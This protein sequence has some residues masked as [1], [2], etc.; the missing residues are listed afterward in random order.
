MFWP[1]RLRVR[2]TTIPGEPT[3]KS[4]GERQ[5]LLNTTCCFSLQTLWKNSGWPET[6]LPFAGCTFSGTYDQYGHSRNPER[7]HSR[8]DSL[9]FQANMFSPPTPCSLRASFSQWTMPAG[10]GNPFA[11]AGW[12]EG[13]Q[14]VTLLLNFHANTDH[15]ESLE[16]R[17]A[18][19][20]GHFCISYLGRDGREGRVTNW[21]FSLFCRL[22]SCNFPNGIRA[23]QLSSSV[24]KLKSD[25]GGMFRILSSVRV[26]CAGWYQ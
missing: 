19:P 7:S 21:K 5:C 20:A 16:K 12:R 25:L 13:P 1:R 17:L 23:M 3:Q 24:L 8:E 4:V 18:V 9:Q 26:T 6:G 14:M 22:R 15:K 10:A 11:S 2:K